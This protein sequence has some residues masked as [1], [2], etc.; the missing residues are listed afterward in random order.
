[1]LEFPK[2]EKT[3]LIKGP[4]GHL[5]VI[6]MRPN[7]SE[8]STTG[9]ICHPHPLHGG[10][11]NNKVVTTIAKAFDQLGL[12]TVRFNFRGVGKSEGKYDDAIGETED[13][14]TVIQWIKHIYPND[15][16]WLA[17]FS[18]GSY[19]AAKAANA[20]AAITQLITVAPTVNH[21]DY[22]ALTAIT[23]PWLIVLGT[24]DELIPFAEVQAFVNNPPVPVKF[25]TIAGASHFFHGRLVELKEALIRELS[26]TIVR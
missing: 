3:F 23:C 18:F 26:C 14:K 15:A 22:Y 11:M 17:G 8:K 2:T 7:E 5:E 1:M 24:Q 21:Y 10:T 20:N 12:K 25:I 13:L 9:I 4:A 19:V 6:T 16:I